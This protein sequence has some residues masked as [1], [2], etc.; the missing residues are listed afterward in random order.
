LNWV[1]DKWCDQWQAGL[2]FI[3]IETSVCESNLSNFD[4]LALSFATLQADVE[5]YSPDC[6]VIKMLKVGTL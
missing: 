3:Y 1:V 5:V 4:K 2:Q 6:P